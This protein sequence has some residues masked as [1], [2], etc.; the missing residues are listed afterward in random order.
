[1]TTI[2]YEGVF[3]HVDSQGNETKLYPDIK[4]DTTLNVSG[5]AADAATVGNRL[6]AIEGNV[7]T[8]EGNVSTIEEN[9]STIEGNVSALD[10]SISALSA[11]LGTQATYSVSGSTLTITTK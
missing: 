8:I 2:E 4:T 10:S 6:T 11:S 7:S 1:M 9:V 3:T 5:K